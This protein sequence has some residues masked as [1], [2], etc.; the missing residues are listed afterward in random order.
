M[1]V[2]MFCIHMFYLQAAEEKAGMEELQRQNSRIL[3]NLLPE[4]V[5]NHFLHLQNNSHMVRKT[6]RQRYI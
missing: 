6:D 1:Y 3:C 5:A 2:Y 4:H